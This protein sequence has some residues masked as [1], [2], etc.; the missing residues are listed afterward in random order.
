MSSDLRAANIHSTSAP[1]VSVVIPVFNDDADNLGRCLA[2]L[3]Q[4]TYP[5][6]S[7]EVIVVD[8]GSNPPLNR[9]ARSTLPVQIIRCE[10]PGAYA[11]RNAGATIARGNILAFT[12]ADCVPDSDWILQAVSAVLSGNDSY[13][14]GD[15]L[16]IQPTVRSGTSLY[17]MAVGFQ[18]KENIERKG[19]TATANLICTAAQFKGVGPFDENLL[20]GG[21][22]EWC[23]RAARHGFNVRFCPDAVVHT[24]PRMTLRDAVRQARRVS[25]GRR[26]LRRLEPANRGAIAPH[27]TVTQSI[28]WIASLP[29]YS[30]W[31]RVRM[32][33]VGAVLRLFTGVESFKLRL[34]STAE[35]R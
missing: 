12:D 15:V 8:N 32:L 25:A 16:F 13:I 24:M 2:G 26:Q 35:R 1:L 19:F 17:Q 14:G 30:W 4:Q 20:S 3:A 31:D 27:R 34:G 11:A 10:K 28:A 23:W 22:R 7:F 29:H 9:K 21:D 6:D 18:Q 33:T 5:R